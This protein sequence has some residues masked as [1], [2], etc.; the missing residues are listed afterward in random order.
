MGNNSC[1]ACKSCGGEQNIEFN[2]TDDTN[3]SK[4]LEQ[5]RQSS[6][7]TLL[8]QKYRNAQYI[9]DQ[10][11]TSK[12]HKV[13]KNNKMDQMMM[14]NTKSVIIIQS[15]ARGQLA[16]FRM[17]QEQIK[18]ENYK[19]TTKYFTKEELFETLSNKKKLNLTTARNQTKPP[20]KYRNGAIYVG[21]WKGGFR[22]GKGRMEWPDGAS[23]EGDWELGYANGQGI[24][25]DE[26]G[27][28]YEGQFYMS[29]AHGHGTYT[30][31]EGSVYEGEWK[32]DKQDGTGIEKL[33]N[34]SVYEGLYQGGSKQGL[35]QMSFSESGAHYR[36]DWFNGVMQGFG[37]YTWKDGKQYTGFMTKNNMEGIGKLIWPDN[38]EYEGQ[39]VNDQKQGYGFY[40]WPDG[41]LFQGWWHL[42]KQH[43]IGKYQK[44]DKEG[45]QLGLWQMGKRLMWFDDNQVQLVY[46]G[47]LDYTQF[48]TPDT[49]KD[50]KDTSLNH[51]EVQEKY[52]KVEKLRK[53]RLKGE[54]ISFD[55]PQS[56]QKSLLKFREMASRLK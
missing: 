30:N 42:G 3:D 56:V 32:N 23:Y 26:F 50:K 7:Q 41:R 22:D 27:N 14:N 47:K 54:K 2:D 31:T 10:T 11:R 15:W 19:R 17:R 33:H 4:A 13:I 53:E 39:F 44:D 28:V 25:S 16:R 48:F 1:T 8:P 12:T 49:S 34:G 46:Q 51:Q 38:K 6:D 24:F 21:Q 55:C 20:H 9:L 18:R 37:Q 45:E 36:G 29:M 52:K 40:Y 35:G 43:G 5:L